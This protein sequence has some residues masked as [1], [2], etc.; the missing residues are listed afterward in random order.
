MVDKLG[1]GHILPIPRPRPVEKEDE[2]RK[3]PRRREE[4][5]QEEPPPAEDAH[6]GAHI[7]D[8]V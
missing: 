1:P 7:D 8:H 3:P 5:E 2:Q 4:P 6:K